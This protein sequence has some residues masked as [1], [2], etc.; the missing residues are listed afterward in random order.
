LWGEY[1]K[2]GVYL[3]HIA[4]NAKEDSVGIFL[5]FLKILCFFILLLKINKIGVGRKVR[6][7]RKSPNGVKFFYK[8]QL[9]TEIKRIKVLKLKKLFMNC[10]KATKK[11]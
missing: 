5:I 10:W 7:L 1:L 6:L 11:C 4:K 2:N 3:E 9:L 8:Q